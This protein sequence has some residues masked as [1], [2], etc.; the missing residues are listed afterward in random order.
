MSIGS[1]VE[2]VVL[3]QVVFFGA[4]VVKEKVQHC[5]EKLHE[6]DRILVAGSSLQV[7]SG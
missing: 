6:C 4:N 3:Y 1:I 7:M 5:F 2:L